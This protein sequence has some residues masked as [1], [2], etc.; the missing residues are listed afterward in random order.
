MKIK[1]IFMDVDGVLTDGKINVD[2]TGKELFKSFCS[3]DTV[4]IIKAQK[5]GLHVVWISAKES[6]ITRKRAESLGIKTVYISTE[7]GKKVEVFCA[8]S[9]I[10]MTD[11]CFIGD[12]D[13]DIEAMRL[14][15]CPIAV[16]NAV[17]DVKKA[18]LYI[19]SRSGGYGAVREAIEYV[20]DRT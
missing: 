5:A 19:T 18:A 16:A 4:G 8:E 15:G 12:D 13:A 14:V 17:H 11:A 7:K 3:Q 6:D 9:G 1:V 10:A 20:L 2:A